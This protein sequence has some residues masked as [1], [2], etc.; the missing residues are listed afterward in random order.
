MLSFLK[1]EK[2]KQLEDKLNDAQRR[3]G[4]E[5]LPEDELFTS[6]GFHAEDAEATASSNYSY[7]GST[8]RAFL[9]N[10]AAVA[11]LI[12]LAAVVAFAFLQPYLPGQADPNLCAVDPVT[13]IQYRN[14]A[15]GQDGFVWGSNSI[16]QDLWARI[17]AGARTSL[18][19]PSSR[20][21]WASPPVCCGAMCAGWTSCSPSCTTSSITSPPPSC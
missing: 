1:R 4:W 17:W 16:G 20:P 5:D 10:K 18:T 8:F 13:G 9:K 12:A 3:T 21:W 2:S 11:L 7:W 19:W 15:P 6:A 14:I